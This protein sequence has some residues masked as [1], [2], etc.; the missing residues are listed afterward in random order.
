MKWGVSDLVR[1]LNVRLHNCHHMISCN[2][3]EWIEQMTIVQSG[4][5]QL[6][7]MERITLNR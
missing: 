1:S 5:N 6:T 7:D 2:T 3:F 4:T